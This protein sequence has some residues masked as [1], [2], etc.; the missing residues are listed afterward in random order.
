VHVTQLC[1]EYLRDREKWNMDQFNL[2]GT[3]IQQEYHRAWN[4]FPGFPGMKTIPTATDSIPLFNASVYPS[5]IRI[6]PVKVA[7][8]FLSFQ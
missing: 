5:L 2:I 4:H 7:K 1:H 3:P 6:C 8:L